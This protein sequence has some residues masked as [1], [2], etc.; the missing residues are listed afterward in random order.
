MQSAIKR[1]VVTGDFVERVNNTMI[2]GKV[3]TRISL[4]APPARIKTIISSVKQSE[5]EMRSQFSAALHAAG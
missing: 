1:F 5:P 3:G 4:I 2:T